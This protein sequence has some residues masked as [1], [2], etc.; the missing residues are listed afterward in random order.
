MTDVPCSGCRRCC[1]SDAVR[2]LPDELELYRTEPHPYAKG[3]RMLAH[4]PNGECYYLGLDG[5]SIH[6]TRPQLC[7]DMDCRNIARQISFTRARKMNMTRIWRRGKE[8]IAAG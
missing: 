6:E 5:C 3:H 7:R 2:L 8:L 4:K 1:I